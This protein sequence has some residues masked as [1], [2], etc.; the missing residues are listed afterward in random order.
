MD[1]LALHHQQRYA[2]PV[3]FLLNLRGRADTFLYLPFSVYINSLLSMSVLRQP[4]D[5]IDEDVKLTMSQA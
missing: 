5:G 1:P 2:F 4:A 3:D